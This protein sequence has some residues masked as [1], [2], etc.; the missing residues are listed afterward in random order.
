MNALPV[1]RAGI[2]S[3]A[4]EIMERGVDTVIFGHTHRPGIYDLKENRKYANTGSWIGATGYYIEIKMGEVSLK[5]WN[6]LGA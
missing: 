6:G 5:E 4:A 2:I 1:E 3:A